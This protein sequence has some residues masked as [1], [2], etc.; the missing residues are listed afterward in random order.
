M[1]KTDFQNIDE[2]QQGFSGEALERMQTIR[3]IIHQEVP[4]VTEAISYQ[5][6]CFKYKGY[7]LYYCAFPKHVSISHPYSAAFWEQFKAELK[8]YKTSKSVIQFPLNEPFPE[9]LVKDIVRYR[10]KEN[11]ERQ[12]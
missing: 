4:N 6:P 7:L 8:G 12:K 5:I 10:K 2:Y 1:A 3:S 11:E 9:K